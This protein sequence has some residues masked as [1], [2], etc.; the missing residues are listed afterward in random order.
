MFKKKIKMARRIIYTILIPLVIAYVLFIALL[1]IPFW[2]ITG[3]N[4]LF[5]ETFKKPIK[6]HDKIIEK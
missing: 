5:N 2:I 4:L 1:I 3:Q 6:L